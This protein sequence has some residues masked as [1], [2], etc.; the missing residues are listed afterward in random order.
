MPFAFPSHQGLILPLWRWFP[1]HLEGVSL[2]VGA[3]MPDVVDAMAAPF[4][5][6]LG[7]WGGH[8]LLG[9]VVACIPVGLALTWLVRRVVPA[10]FLARLDDGEGAAPPT[11]GRVSFSLGVGAL[12]HV[13]FDLIT[14]GNFLVLW[15]FYRNDHAFPA[16][17]SRPWASVPLFVYKEPYPIA[18][19]TVVWF[20][21]T[22]LGAV[23]F[24]RCLRPPRP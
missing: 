1:R 24:F 9:V 17:W 6:E 16:W 19:H 5:G 14:H 13:I 22:V 21:L 23:L 18:P 12:S 20:V 10:R 4:R 15:P 3:A 8:S 2:S 11:L 7:Q